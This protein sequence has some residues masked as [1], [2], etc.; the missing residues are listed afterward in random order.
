[1]HRVVLLSLV[2]AT[3][4]ACEREEHWYSYALSELDVRFTESLHVDA[5][6]TI[7]ADAWPQQEAVFDQS[8]RIGMDGGSTV[9]FVGAV[10]ADHSLELDYEL[11]IPSEGNVN[12]LEPFAGCDQ[13]SD[14][15]RTFRFE[16]TCQ[17]DACADTVIADAYISKLSRSRPVVM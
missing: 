16:F 4:S 1:M 13:Q 14:C 5:R 11:F 10:A 15:T 3:L 6:I 17:Q 8:V 12:V 2:A 7:P 9:R